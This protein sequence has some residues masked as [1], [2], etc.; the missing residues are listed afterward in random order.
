MAF[1][2][3]ERTFERLPRRGFPGGSRIE[4]DC[5]RR[6]Q[7]EFLDAHQH[8]GLSLGEALTLGRR[9][10]ERLVQRL[11]AGTAGLDELSEGEITNAPEAI[12]RFGQSPANLLPEEVEQRLAVAGRGHLHLHP[13]A[14][15]P[16]DSLR[17]AVPGIGTPAL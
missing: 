11:R 2:P 7:F 4:A 5:G 6:G 15:L 10:A 8:L 1:W 17:R 3:V 13:I 9:D 14:E 12:D 16:V